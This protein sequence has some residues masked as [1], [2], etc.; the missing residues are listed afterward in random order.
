MTYDKEYSDWI[1]QPEQFWKDKASDIDWFTFPNTILSQDSDGLSHWFADGQ[2]NTCYLALDHHIENGHGTQTALIYD[3]PVTGVK[4]TYNYQELKGQVAKTAGML[5]ARGVTKGDTVIIYMPMIPEAAIA[6]LACARIG[7]VHSV[8]FGGFAASELASRIDDAKPKIIMSA[9]CGIEITK[10]IEYKPL[11]DGAIEQSS[12]KPQHCIIY[13]RPQ[14]TATMLDDRDLD[15]SQ[16]LAGAKEVDP[17]PVAGSDPL[18]IL[19]TSGTTGKPK[20]VVRTNGGHA[21]ALKYSMRAIYGLNP[22]DTF[23]TASDIGWVVGHSYI[24][25]APLISQCTTI[26]YEGKPILTPD[27]GSFW[28]LIQDY[29]VSAMF[30]A[31]TAFR[32]IRRED[33]NGDLIKKYDISSL[34]HVFAAGERLDP[35]T[36]QWMLDKIGV[37]IIDN[38]WQTETGWP[39]AANMTG[40]EK[41]NIKFGSATKPI[42][43]YQIEILDDEGKA[44]ENGSQGNVAIKLPLPPGCL[45]TLW[46]ATERFKSEYLSDYPG[47]YTSGDGGYFD[48]DGYL[49]VMGRVDDVINIAGHR[50]STGDIEEVLGK[51]ASVAECAV[52]AMDDSLKGEIPVGFVVPKSSEQ[53]KGQDQQTVLQSD[54]QTL[55]RNEIG[56]IACYQKT[57]VVPRLPKTRSGKILR[58]TMKHILNEQEY[59]DP[60]TIE[61]PTALD[62]IIQTIAASKS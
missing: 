59:V 43:G 7:A 49:F 3:S 46:N 37:D 36:Q 56:P 35:P 24:V 55:V 19:Y 23:L 54:L 10:S 34:R 40:I 60:P 62:E 32:A 47:Y 9:S 25:Y 31:P 39:I 18:Y 57:F 15:W 6:M 20:G 4:T 16:E 13:Q 1:N 21:V 38:W 11:L 50:L 53:S 8:V 30:S 52:V 45:A 26:M 12:H 58:K 2:L 41:L 33:E 17:V 48:E 44:V 22:G 51:H 61:D 5:A 29:K 28:R 42:P 27:A 14:A